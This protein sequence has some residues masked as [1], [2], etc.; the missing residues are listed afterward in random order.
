MVSRMPLV[1][2]VRGAVL[3]QPGAYRSARTLNIT[4]SGVVLRGSGAGRR[5]HRH[6]PHRPPRT[7]SCRIRGPAARA[8]TG[9]KVAITDDYVPAG[10]SSF[11]VGDASSFKVGDAVRDRP[12][13]D[14]GLD[15]LHGHG[16]AGA[17]RRA[18]DLA[19]TPGSCT[20]G[21]A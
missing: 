7:C 6:R 2:G 17:R 8:I 15:R 21:S 11:T 4:A 5:R 20:P 16:Q 14:G 9:P 3:L 13:G 18:A 12:A 19:R 1:N 10:A